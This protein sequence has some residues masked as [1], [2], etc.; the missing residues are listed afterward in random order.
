MVE[1]LGYCMAELMVERRDHLL[2]GKMAEKSGEKK[3]ALSVKRKAL[4]TAG[5][6]VAQ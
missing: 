5:H 6:W 1:S 2:A 3:V 4:K